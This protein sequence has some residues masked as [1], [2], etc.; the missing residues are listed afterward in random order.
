MMLDNLLYE[1]QF[2]R[3]SSQHNLFLISQSS[4]SVDFGPNFHREPLLTG[5]SGEFV[6]TAAELSCANFDGN[7]RW[8]NL[9]HGEKG[10]DFGILEEIF[11]FSFHYPRFPDL[12]ILYLS[13][14]GT[15]YKVNIYYLVSFDGSGISLSND[16][17]KD[18][19]NSLIFD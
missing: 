6:Q 18:L 8:R 7:C 16:I 1:A 19:F 4:N 14:K 15:K 13:C 10:V 5:A 9:G 2:C 11:K 3:V 17:K 12:R